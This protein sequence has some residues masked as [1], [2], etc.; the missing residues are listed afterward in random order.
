[1]ISE[2][3]QNFEK[4]IEMICLNIIKTVYNENFYQF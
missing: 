3:I 1:M 4:K 2:L